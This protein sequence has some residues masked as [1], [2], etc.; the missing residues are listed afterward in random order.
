MLISVPSAPMPWVPIFKALLTPF[1]GLMTVLIAFQQWRANRFKLVLDRYERRLAVYRAV[2]SF[3]GIVQRDFN[4]E[5]PHLQA[6][7]ASTADAH[8]LFTP[9]IP[10]YLDEI[11]KR[12]M[13]LRAAHRQ[14]RDLTQV[15]QPGYDHNKVVEEMHEQETWFI[16]Q[17]SAARAIFKKHLDISQ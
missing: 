11:A 3:L 15:P 12:A 16:N 9:E 8:F 1:I 13:A 10:A 7:Y 4:P 2:V 17:F 5:L 14:Y 6:F